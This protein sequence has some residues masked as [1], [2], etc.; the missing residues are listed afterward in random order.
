M[1]RANVHVL[2]GGS[3]E[4]YFR[5]ATRAA[6]GVDGF[7]EGQLWEKASHSGQESGDYLMLWHY[8]DRKSAEQALRVVANERPLASRQ[9]VHHR[10]ADVSR[11]RV[12]STRRDKLP[13]GEFLSASVR[14]ANPGYGEDLVEEVDRIFEELGLIPGFRGAITGANDTLPEEVVGL[15][16][17][18]SSEAYQASLPDGAFVDVELFERV[19]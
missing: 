13:E 2:D 18:N 19:A 17:W 3:V 11:I 9:V 4:T 15:A 12:R 7:L 5:D 8:R 1:V 10:P 6:T 16:T 14:V